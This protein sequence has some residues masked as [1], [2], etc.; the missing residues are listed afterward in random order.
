[1]VI[2]GKNCQGNVQ[3]LTI[4]V[5]DWGT[6][7]LTVWVTQVILQV[8]CLLD[9]AGNL[10]C[11]CVRTAHKLSQNLEQVQIRIQ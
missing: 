4:Y 5:R 1:M 11:V 9:K 3:I 8:S 6:G 2:L 10:I 7:S